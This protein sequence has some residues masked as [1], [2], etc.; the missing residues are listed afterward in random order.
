MDIKE[1]MEM[2]FKVLAVTDSKLEENNMSADKEFKE[3]VFD[4]IQYLRR[5]EKWIK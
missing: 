3:R 5:M 2:Q 1:I 4:N